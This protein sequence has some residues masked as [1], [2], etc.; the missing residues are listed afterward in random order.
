M[1]SLSL[2]VAV[3][4]AAACHLGLRGG[5]FAGATWLGIVGAGFEA[6]TVGGFADWFAVTALFRHPLGLP[7]PHTAIIPTRRAKII[8][9]IVT[10]VE[11]DWLSPDVI[12]ARLARMAP[13]T[14]VVDWLRDPTHVERV[15][16]PVRDVLRGLAP[17]LGGPEAVGFLERT[18]QRQLRELPV[19]AA[20]GAWLRRAI[21]SDGAAS[22]FATVALSVANLAER[23]RTATQLHWW[24]DRSARTLRAGGRRLIP[25]VL[26][27]RFVQRQLVEAACGYAA[28]ELRAAAGDPQHPLRQAVQGAL[29]GFAER[30]ERGDAKALADVEWLRTAVVESLEAGPLVRDALARLRAQ[31][32][33]DLDDPHGAL[34]ALVDRWLRSAAVDR[35]AEPQRRVAFDQWVRRTAD[36]L[37]R[38]YHNEIGRTVRENLE[39]LETGRLVAQ[40]EERVGADLQFIRLNGAVV[41]GLVGVVL[42]LARWLMG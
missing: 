23:P 8:E 26:R 31:L 37:L 16:A 27:R 9:G 12:S 13:S 35:L 28:A 14:L 36:E 15:S 40:I 1:G 5:P 18:L 6:A 33:Q 22:A 17:T 3:G 25:F 30:L 29:L 4:G 7:I 32:E 10:M 24:L 11:E 2:A 42:A 38:R 21:A 20:A 41:G 34:A 19:D 39:A